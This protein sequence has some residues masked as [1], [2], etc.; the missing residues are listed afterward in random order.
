MLNTTSHKGPGR[1]RSEADILYLERLRVQ[2]LPIN[3]DIFL[4]PVDYH[5][6]LDIIFGYS[7]D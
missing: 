7:D 6:N 1:L 4:L 2:D 5:D 3:H